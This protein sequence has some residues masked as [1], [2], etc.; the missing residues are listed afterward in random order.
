MI[1]DKSL[2][3]IGCGES[4]S[5]TVGE[6]S[7]FAEK[8]LTN[9]PKRCANCRILVRVKRSGGDTKSVHA[10]ECAECGAPVIVP[11]HPRGHKPI[12]CTACLRTKSSAQS[13]QSLAV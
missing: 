9:E 10:T 1:T 12:Y 8:G 2:K 4:F 5:F 11:F 13:T 6:Q 3:C 7:F